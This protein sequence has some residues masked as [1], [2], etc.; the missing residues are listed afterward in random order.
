MSF[1]LYFI[2]ISEKMNHLD[3]GLNRRYTSSMGLFKKKL[4]L[5]PFVTTRMESFLQM[6]RTHPIQTENY[7]DSLSQFAKIFNAS[8]A[9]VYVY[10][11]KTNLMVLKK[12]SGT[13][14]NRFSISA[15]F[16]FVEYLKVR[17]DCVRRSEFSVKQANELRQPA[18]LYFQHTVSTVAVPMMDNDQWY[19]VVNVHFESVSHEQDFFMD[20][21]FELYADGLKRWLIYQ[22]VNDQNRKYSEISQVKNQLLANV[23]HELQTPL[24]GILGISSALLDDEHL[25]ELHR[26]SVKLIKKSGEELHKTVNN[27]LELMQ[28]ESKRNKKTREKINIL[29]VIHEVAMLF[30]DTCRDKKLK[31]VIPSSEDEIPVYVQA[32][33]L[34]TVF[35]NLLGNAVK[36]TD[37]GEIRIGVHKSGEN[38]HV[39][40][41][42]TGIGID[43]DKIGLIFEEFYQGDGTHTRVY[44]GTG[45]GLAI[46]KKIINLHGG[47]IWVESQKGQGSRFEFTLPLYPV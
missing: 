23:T 7:L 25:G 3:L 17:G 14:P 41:S 4:S 44:G 45:L 11:Q 5:D 28:I 35:M 19:G 26:G 39:Y 29:D 36:F 40:V 2:G 22:R 37:H 12:W 33:Q 18:L 13:K 15:D 38:L 9:S 42:D 21:L 20:A 32:D 43:E 34:R 30:T 16:E 27:I 1:S 24:N 46:V 8:S 31:I 10:E 47:R 6:I